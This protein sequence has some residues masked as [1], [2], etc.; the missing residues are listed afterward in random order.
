MYVSQP[1]GSNQDGV[2]NA[3]VM[4]YHEHFTVQEEEEEAE[5][6]EEREKQNKGPCWPRRWR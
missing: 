2:G 5:E 1:G 4:A 3:Q 6:E